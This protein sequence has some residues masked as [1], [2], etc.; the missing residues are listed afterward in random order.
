MRKILLIVIIIMTAVT[1]ELKAQQTDLQHIEE[2]VNYYLT[3]LVNNDAKTLTKAFHPTATMK[4]I[5]D[6]YKEVNAIEGLTEGMDGTPH[7][8]KITT[9]VVSV[10]I[11]G[12]AA[13]AQLEIQF[14]TFTYIDFMH[15]LKVDGEWKI[16]SKIFYTRQESK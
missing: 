8:E 3:G 2:T 12:D 5:G 4:W 1:T 10:N 16:V 7:K 6:D 9:R 11:A 13:S 14:P 15:L